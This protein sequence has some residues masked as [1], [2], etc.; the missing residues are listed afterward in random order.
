MNMHRNTEHVPLNRKQCK[1]K[2]R[3]DHQSAWVTLATKINTGLKSPGWLNGNQ[4]MS[5]C[6]SLGIIILGASCAFP[7]V[8]RGM[9]VQPQGAWWAQGHPGFAVSLPSWCLLPDENPACSVADFS[10]SHSGV[11]MVTG[12]SHPPLIETSFG[13]STKEKEQVEPYSSQMLPEIA[14]VCFH[15]PASPFQDHTQAA[16]K[17]GPAATLPDC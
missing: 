17:V 5:R 11:A 12:L 7:G 16:R 10:R 9:K 1:K 2:K 3:A 4:A 15:S 13:G 8:P 14:M 6:V